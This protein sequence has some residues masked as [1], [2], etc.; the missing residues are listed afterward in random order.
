MQHENVILKQSIAKN[1]NGTTHHPDELDIINLIGKATSFIQRFKLILFG[2]AIVGLSF[3]LYKYFSSPTQFT[4]RL[5]VHSMFL[6]NQEEIEIV[7]NW[8]ELLGKGE[9]AQLAKLLNCDITVIE[10]LGKISAEEILKTY[11]V[12]NPN[13]FIINVTV[14][15]NSILDQLQKGIVYGLNNSPYVKEK[16]ETKKAR[17]RELIKRTTDEIAKLN[18]TKQIIDSLI[19]T[20]QRNSSSFMLDI[21]RISAQTIELNEKLFNY[22]EDLKFLAG[23]Q[24]LENF[25]KGKLSRNG[26]LKLSLLGMASGLFIG[27]LVS[28][29]LFI[30]IKLKTSRLLQ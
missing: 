28:L 12:N 5:I 14:K 29:F 1:G 19:Q 22:Q 27:Y 25:N 8:K 15:D 9:K 21:S 3:G 11:A 2:S 23:I 16:I 6:S 10:K 4:T 7:D 17:D 18:V 30:R 24:V 26:L 20:S 13:G